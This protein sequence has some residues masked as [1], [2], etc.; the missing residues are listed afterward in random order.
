MIEIRNTLEMNS[1]L[2]GSAG[3]NAAVRLPENANIW[4]SDGELNPDRL[5]L[6]ESVGASLG[7]SLH[8]C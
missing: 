1:Y 4:L 7:R 5:A 2:T 6:A 3:G 8:L